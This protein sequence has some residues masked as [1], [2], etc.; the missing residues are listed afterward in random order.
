MHNFPIGKKKNVVLYFWVYFI[1]FPIN[2]SNLYIF[3]VYKILEI[4]N[5]KYL[6]IVVSDHSFNLEIFLSK[7]ILEIL[8][9]LTGYF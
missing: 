6:V 7:S 1:N 9:N 4:H 3:L 8:Q 5:S 2:I